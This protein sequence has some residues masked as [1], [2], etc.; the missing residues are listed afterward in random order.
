M[1]RLAE[2]HAFAQDLRFTKYWLEWLIGVQAELDRAYIGEA[3]IE[4]AITAA[5]K[6][7]DRILNQ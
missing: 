3:S 6:E 1:E 4:D 2:G 7:G 5:V